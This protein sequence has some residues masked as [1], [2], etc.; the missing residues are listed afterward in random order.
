MVEK[1]LVEVGSHY[2][3]AQFV[4]FHA[5]K[6][7]AE[8]GQRGDERLRYFVGVDPAMGIGR[9][10]LTEGGGDHQEPVR[11]AGHVAQPGN[12]S[13]ALSRDRVRE[14]GQNVYTKCEQRLTLNS[15]LKQ[16]A[17]EATL[18][19]N[20]PTLILTGSIM[21]LTSYL[22]ESTRL[23]GMVDQQLHFYFVKVGLQADIYFL[24]VNGVESSAI[25]CTILFSQLVYLIVKTRFEWRI[26]SLN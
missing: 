16:Y 2:L 15:F 25:V 23:R 10:D 8:T 19:V 4:G 11:V 20:V 13:P 9:F 18:F 14:S 3:S 5:K 6:G 22:D 1:P 17:K 21:L 26:S 12:E 24:F 7:H